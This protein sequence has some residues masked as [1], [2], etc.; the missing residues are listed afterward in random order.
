MY[1]GYRGPW[2]YTV[3]VSYDPFEDVQAEYEVVAKNEEDAEE[4]AWF[5]ARKDLAID[6][7]VEI[8]DEGMYEVIISFAGIED[9]GVSYVVEAN[10]SDEA[11]EIA[12]DQ[13]G[14]ELST[15]VDRDIDDWE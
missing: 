5:E 4:A 8:E 2:K 7:I 1:H 6:D 3:I 13:A 10:D 15:F 12:L 11:A 9:S 14:R